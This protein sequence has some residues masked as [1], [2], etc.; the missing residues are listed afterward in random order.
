MKSSCGEC[1]PSYLETI[2]RIYFREH[3]MPTRLHAKTPVMY[4]KDEVCPL[5]VPPFTKLEL[6][7]MSRRFCM[8]SV[9]AKFHS[10]PTG[11]NKIINFVEIDKLC[12]AHISNIHPCPLRWDSA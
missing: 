1:E 9:E 2:K 11:L 8:I 5:S 12:R 3:P 10:H 4:K 6:G 7:F